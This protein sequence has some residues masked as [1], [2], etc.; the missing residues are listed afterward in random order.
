VTARAIED[1]LANATE[2]SYQT[3]FCHLLNA[4]GYSVIHSTTHGPAE[5]GKDIIA[6]DINGRI[7]AFQLKRGNINVAEW[8]KIKSEID[9]LV[10]LPIRL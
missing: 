2:R 3:A 7:I 8:R 10:E 4:I 1:W 9:E 6:K 5:E